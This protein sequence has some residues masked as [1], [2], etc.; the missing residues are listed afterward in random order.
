M[1]GQDSFCPGN[2]IGLGERQPVQDIRLDGENERF[3]VRAV[4]DAGSYRHLAT[5]L[6]RLDAVHPVDDPVVAFL[7]EDRR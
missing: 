4:D 1:R 7:D 6:R 3:P 5:Q 2:A